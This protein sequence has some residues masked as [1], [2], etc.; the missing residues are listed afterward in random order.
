MISTVILMMAGCGTNAGGKA[1][2][3]RGNILPKRIENL[4]YEDVIPEGSEA[5]WVEKYDATAFNE[6]MLTGTWKRT[7]TEGET[8]VLE[9]PAPSGSGNEALRVNAF[10]E[11][12]IFSNAK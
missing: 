6:R 5:G 9:V 3:L 2:N 4:S 7:R 12:M 11:N 10:P 8:E 1:V